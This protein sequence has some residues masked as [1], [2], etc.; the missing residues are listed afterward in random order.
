MM[1]DDFLQAPSDHLGK[2]HFMFR[3]QPFRFAEKPVWY[4]HLCL[5]H[6]SIL[7]SIYWNINPFWLWYMRIGQ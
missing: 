7:P 1:P 5:N 4:L 2:A 6:D 3:R